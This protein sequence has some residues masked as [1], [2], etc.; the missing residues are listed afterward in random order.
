MS[1]LRMSFYCTECA[2]SAEL[3]D[4]DFELDGF[5]WRCGLHHG[6]V[7]YHCDMSVCEFLETISE[8]S[9]Q[10]I[11]K[12]ARRIQVCSELLKDEV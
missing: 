11:A 1:K 2:A 7:E 8:M 12:N 5:C 3:K 6:N 10:E 4:D 9:E